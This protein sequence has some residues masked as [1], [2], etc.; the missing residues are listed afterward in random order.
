MRKN[1]IS[2]GMMSRVRS[3]GLIVCFF[4]LPVL[5]FSAEKGPMKLVD[6]PVN[7]TLTILEGDTPALTYQYGDRLPDGVPKGYIHSTYIHPLHSLDGE[8]LT[9]DFPLDH[10][11]HHGLFWTWPYVKTRGFK[12]QT[13]HP[14]NP[15]LR[16]YFV[17]WL[18]MG[19][20]NGAAVVEAEN[21][22]KLNG[23]ETVARE[24][25]TLYVH[26]AGPSGR[27]VDIGIVL[28]AVGGP[29]EVKGTDEGKK[30]YGGLCL[31]GASLFKGCVLTTDEGRLKKDTTNTPFL[32]ADMSTD[33]VGV[34]VFP[35]TGHPGF[36][37]HWLIRNS[38]AGVIN[39]S[40]PGL[41]AHVLKDGESVTL[42]YRIYIHRG[43]AETGH[44]QQA[45][46]EYIKE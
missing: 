45:Y 24:V 7:G 43:D 42:T 8:V 46:R 40:W 39:V 12:T 19:E 44:V 1:R 11:H 14:D 23:E 28:T 17:R 3:A 18:K 6:D 41:D 4:L 26:P 29:L 22:W 32:W 38:Y 2:W 9:E 30:G 33:K 25:V 10:L 5:A 27:A 36:P 21:T 35:F 20:K 16:Q 37:V 31:R 15:S 34:A 13:W